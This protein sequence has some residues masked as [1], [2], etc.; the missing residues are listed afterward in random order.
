MD[1]K[2][3]LSRERERERLEGIY[4]GSKLRGPIGPSGEQGIKGEKGDKGEKGPKGDK[5]DKD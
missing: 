3:R 2:Q 5:G 1:R 4:R